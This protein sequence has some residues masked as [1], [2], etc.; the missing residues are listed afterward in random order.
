[1]QTHLTCPS[2]V[3]V[4]NRFPNTLIPSLC[5]RNVSNLRRSAPSRASLCII[6]S[7]NPSTVLPFAAVVFSRQ[8][9]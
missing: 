3:T 6:W 8:P 7:E 2:L 4:L 9:M 1:M 5:F